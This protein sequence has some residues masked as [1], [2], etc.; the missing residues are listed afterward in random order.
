MP[1]GKKASRGARCPPRANRTRCAPQHSPARP[2][3]QGM[4]L[5]RLRHLRPQATGGCRHPPVRRV[6]APP[7][8]PKAGAPGCSALPSRRRRRPRLSL[9]EGRLSPRLPRP[10]PSWDPGL[11]RCPPPLPPLQKRGR[12]GLFPPAA[13][14]GG[15]GPRRARG[16]WVDSHPAGQHR[17]GDP[18]HPRGEAVSTPY[19]S[20]TL[21]SLS[22]SRIWV[23]MVSRTILRALSLMR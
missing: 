1:L 12:A 4:G 6:M 19:S 8:S 20:T 18:S 5:P 17:S 3:A 7:P 16:R 14:G 13:V 10:A 22:A 15:T 2:A 23:I 9:P 11:Q 21:S